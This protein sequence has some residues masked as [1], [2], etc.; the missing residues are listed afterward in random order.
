LD[1]LAW[2]M[3]AHRLFSKIAASAATISLVI[4]PTVA[5]A[6][7]IMTQLEI[8]SDHMRQKCRKALANPKKFL[9][10]VKAETLKDFELRDY[11]IAF[12]EGKYGC[13]KNTKFVFRT[14]DSF[15]SLP[16]RKFS[17]PW[18]LRRY[19]FAWPEEYEP[20]N[21][22]YVY[23]L[24]WLFDE[25]RSYLPKDWTSAEA[26]AFVDRPGHWKIA[27]AKFGNSRE[28]DDAVFASVSD[29]QSPHFDRETAV[30]LSAF[31]SKNQLLRKVIAASLY[32]DPRIGQPDFAKAESLLPISGLYSDFVDNP[33]QQKA[34]AA[35][36]Q[37]IDGYMQ[38][39]DAALRKK[40]IQ[41][42]EEMF[43]TTLE[44]WPTIEHPKDGRVWLS[45]AD[46]P[47][48]A[49][50]P[51]DSVNLAHVMTAD[52]YPARAM[53]NEE[54]GRVT[55]AASFGPEGKFSGL[56]VIQSSGSA[57]LD[58]TAVKTMHRRI[59][60]KLDEM[61]LAGYQGREVRVPLL[62]VNW[63]LGD[64]LSETQGTTRY[65]NGTLSI[66]ARTFASS[67]DGCGWPPSFFI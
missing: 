50:N 49:K 67:V 43:L 27:L 53:R 32:T 17:S 46:W 13:R 36:V 19:A 64:G 55:I 9:A 18:L 41:L 45:L 25:N 38:S 35:W 63:Q 23:N 56:E 20:V 30:Q 54:A 34:H 60:P 48:T 39:N 3:T 11:V 24:L 66:T 44:K 58:E 4:T 29:P 6:C 28:R 59:R 40:G 2:V 52:D 51:F 31:S 61:T 26:R 12:D 15:Y 14:L 5:S 7:T 21:R 37:I 22:A 8:S 62:A 1:D 65:A 47:K 16:E 33:V 10:K 57:L 42:K